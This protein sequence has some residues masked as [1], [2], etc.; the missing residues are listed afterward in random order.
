MTDRAGNVLPHDHLTVTYYGVQTNGQV[1]NSDK[2][3]VHAGAYTATALYLE[4]DEAGAIV[5][6]GMALGV[7]LIKPAET[8]TVV[9]DAIKAYDEDGYALANLIQVTT[10]SGVNPDT[11]IL[12]ASL[13]A[14][15]DFSQDGFAAV[16]G[17]VNVDFPAWLDQILAEQYPQD[18]VDGVNAA[19]VLE[20]F[21]SYEAK[22]TE[23]GISAETIAAVTNVLSKLPE[24]AA[25]TFHDDVV[26]TQ[27]GVY[28]VMAVV[29]DSD[30]LP[31][32]DTG[33]L[34]I[35]PGAEVD[36]LKFNYEDANNI[37]TQSLLAKIDLGASAYT[38][39]TY[40]VLDEEAT[41]NI[42]NL[43]FHVD[44]T[45]SVVSEADASKLANGAYIQVSYIPFQVDNQMVIS[46]L[47]A[48]PVIIVP[49]TLKVTF[50]DV[51]D[52][53]NYLRKFTYDGQ[54]HDIG[55]VEVS[56]LDGTLVDTAKGTL[57]VTYLGV[58]GDG[59]GYRST[60][61]P[62]QA[63]LYTVIAAYVE[64]DGEKVLRSG[65]MVGGLLIEKAAMTFDLLDTTVDYNGQSQFVNVNNPENADYISVTVNKA[66]NVAN[67]V[68]EDDLNAL[69][70]LLAENGIEVD[71]EYVLDD[72]LAKVHETLTKA[73]GVEMP[74]FAA[75][76]FKQ[77][78]AKLK[79]V[80]P[81]SGTVTINGDGPV[82]V[83]EY[84]VYAAAYSANYA[85]QLSEGTLTIEPAQV[86]IT[87][88]N[89]SK[90]HGEE[91]PEL[92]CTVTGLVGKDNL[93]IVVA[94]EN[95]SE[96]IGEY[97][98]TATYVSND[99]YVVTVVDGTLVIKD[100]DG[101]LL[102]GTVEGNVLH[103][104]AENLSANDK[105]ANFLV[106][107]YK[108]GQLMEVHLVNDIAVEGKKTW[109]ETNIELDGS[110]TEV[111]FFALDKA[112]CPLA[113]LWSWTADANN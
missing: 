21:K 3:P 54:A 111:K 50:K 25:L 6:L 12:S 101:F 10:D 20:K 71:T 72:L 51:N 97:A 68:L 65:A 64:K 113:E 13:A 32:A 75:A 49:D 27:V 46:D 22:L 98:I 80:I 94:R 5:N 92:T 82:N 16:E 57:T 95:K 7:M 106:A 81:L 83:G 102:D 60:Q 44:E 42:V 4:R 58:E 45:G 69:V 39:A 52:Q 8:A 99:N 26:C 40:A 43:F 110:V 23:L 103:I 88:N 76:A 18:F 85:S 37:F 73:E 17:N 66:A 105:T 47:I 61:A 1:Y 89:A 59:E 84:Q 55:R 62:S 79:D 29:T 100:K 56:E 11:T 19:D 38:D 31:S 93:R 2:A 9:E 53:D 86:T 63:G 28:A 24:N 67:L 109:T 108:D 91:D 14:E 70:D 48:R 96:D 104:R 77:L 33:I 30:H 41:A 78:L 107:T 90:F 34:V 15:G 87:V 36:Y 112:H 35:V 74:E